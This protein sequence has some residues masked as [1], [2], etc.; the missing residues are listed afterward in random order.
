[1]H[2][3]IQCPAVLHNCGALFMHDGK[4]FVFPCPV[5]HFLP[6]SRLPL[7]FGLPPINLSLNF[8]N[9]VMHKEEFTVAE[10]PVYT[11]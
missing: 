2:G 3:H 7:H 9:V 6:S 10:L 11:T 5:L 1:M 8:A 4:L